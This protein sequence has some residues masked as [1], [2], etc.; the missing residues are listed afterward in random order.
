[1]AFRRAH[2]DAGQVELDQALLRE[3]YGEETAR[4]VIALRIERGF[5]DR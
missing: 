4:K 2:P 3:L 1:V 5:Y